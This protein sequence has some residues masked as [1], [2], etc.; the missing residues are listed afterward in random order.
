MRTDGLVTGL[1]LSGSVPGISAPPAST[2][3]VVNRSEASKARV[4]FFCMPLPKEIIET[5]APMPIITPAAVRKVRRRRLPRLARANS[6][7]S[8]TSRHPLRRNDAAVPEAHD[9]VGE[10]ADEGLLV[11]DHDDGQTAVPV[12]PGQQADDLARRPAVEVA[13][14]LVGEEEPRAVGQG[15]G[16]G[17]PLL[18]PARKLRRAGGPARWASPT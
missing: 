9:L 4:M 2:V 5:R 7:A 13:R 8:G 12:E 16:H 3:T 1:R 17:H 11:G 18:L 10:F 6:T 15:P 14:R